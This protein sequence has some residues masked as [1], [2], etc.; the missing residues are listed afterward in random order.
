MLPFDIGPDTVTLVKRVPV[1][2]GDNNP[3]VDGWGIPTTTDEL[4]T[5]DLCS[6]VEAAGTEEIAGTAVAVING[7]AALVVD[8]DT[9]GLTARDAIRFRD[10]TFELISPGVQH[11]DLLGNASHVRAEARWAEDVSIGERVVWVA[12]GARDD[13][14]NVAADAAPVELISR[15]VLAGNQTRRFGGVGE[16][17][18]A[19]FTVVLDLD[20][21]VSDGDWLIIRGRECLALV[22]RQESQWQDRRQLVVLAQHRRGGRG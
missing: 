9:R 21:G 19:D 18:S 16:V 10:R 1:L 14:G 8:D 13:R 20:A 17:I 7:T 15:A 4:I 11:D 3:V 22:G 2:D 12:A 5:K 6:F